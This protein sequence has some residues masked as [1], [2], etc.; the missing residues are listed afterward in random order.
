MAGEIE[1]KQR[2]NIHVYDTD[3]SVG[4][5][6][7][8][9]EACRKAAK[10]I[11]DMLNGYFAKLKGRKS[12]KEIYYMALLEIALLYEK[13]VKRNDVVPFN[14]ILSKLTSEIED[15]LK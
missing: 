14:D 8:D 15:A 10:R 4:V 13:E 1:N 2:I 3:M 6:R 12:D 5:S 9:E 11:S 7:S